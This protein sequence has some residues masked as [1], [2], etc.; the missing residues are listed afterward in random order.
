MED[1][2]A[3]LDGGGQR[4]AVEH[5]GLEQAQALRRPVQLHQVRVLGIA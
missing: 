5:V 1:A 3:P 4:G 2:L